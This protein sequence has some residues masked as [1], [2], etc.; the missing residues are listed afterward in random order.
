MF[1]LNQNKIV[2]I[3]FLLIIISFFLGFFLNEN[4]A[5]A[6]GERGDLSL[7]WNNLILFKTNHILDAVKSQ[8]YSDSRTPFLYI[9]HKLLNPY[10]NDKLSFRISVFCFSILIPFVFFFI[11]KKKFYNLSSSKLLLLSSLLFLSP[12]FRTSAYW[13]L[14]ENYG[15]LTVL[16][17]Y[18]FF[19]EI[20]TKKNINL[21]KENINIFF[22]CFF[23][24]LTIYFDHKLFF[25]PLIIYLQTIFSKKEIN[26]KLKITFTYVLFSLP[27]L[28][29]FYLWGSILPPAVS[30][31]RLIGNFI[32]IDNIGYSSTIIAFYI[33]PF[34]FFK[35]S[36][37][38]FLIKKFFVNKKN[39]YILIL[40]FIYLFVIFFLKEENVWGHAVAGVNEFSQSGKGF[41]YKFILLITKNVILRNILLYV[42]FFISFIIIFIY[43]DNSYTDKLIIT[44]LL[45]S[46]VI[47]FP[48]YQEYFDPLILILIFTFFKTNLFITN[49]KLIFLTIY[50]SLFLLVANIYYFMII[51]F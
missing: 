36:S 43:F 33:L 47:I 12:Y 26:T 13:G 32:H 30:N 14:S 9:I 11:L 8:L 42:G 27:V 6:G 39:Y 18:F 10:T 28:G 49:K 21:S 31:V 2:K 7:I 5:G 48:I 37:F 38:F 40:I 25:I 22:L 41:F 50:L 24:S 1:K 17:S 46:S 45:L 35:K 20:F 15:M 44:L 29:L 51:K 4:S 23:S 34:L 16:L 3:S 19:Y